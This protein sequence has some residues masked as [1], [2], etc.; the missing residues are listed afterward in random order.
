[1]LLANTFSLL[2]GPGDAPFNLTTRMRTIAY[3]SAGACLKLV[4]EP[5]CASMQAFAHPCDQVLDDS[6]HTQTPIF[7]VSTRRDATTPTFI[8]LDD[9]EYSLQTLNCKW[10][11]S[12]T[13]RQ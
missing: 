5:L 13:E 8:E 2:L 12:P 11:W 9:G 1:M 7:R 10:E 4:S 6:S 3:N